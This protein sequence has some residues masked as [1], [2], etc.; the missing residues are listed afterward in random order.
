MSPA[1]WRNEQ[2]RDLIAW[3]ACQRAGSES[4]IF[5]TCKS[6]VFGRDA[7]EVVDGLADRTCN[8]KHHS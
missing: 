1:R 3:V 5:Q 7:M 2:V 8:E 4:Q 6:L